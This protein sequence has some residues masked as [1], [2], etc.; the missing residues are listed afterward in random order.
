MEFEIIEDLEEQYLIEVFSEDSYY[1]PDAP[2]KLYRYT[3]STELK[4][5]QIVQYFIEKIIEGDLYEGLGAIRASEAN[6]LLGQMAMFRKEGKLKQQ[7]NSSTEAKKYSK[8]LIDFLGVRTEYYSNVDSI[9]NPH[10]QPGFVIHNTMLYEHHDSICL[11]AIN[12]KYLLC[13]E[14]SWNYG[15]E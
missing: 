13:I 8:E 10:D 6:T 4:N 5:D 7:E 14:Q 11:I 3:G 12:E 2:S 9:D 15:G 1:D